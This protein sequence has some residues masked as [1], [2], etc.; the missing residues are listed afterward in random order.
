MDRLM[1]FRKYRIL[2]LATTAVLLTACADSASGTAGEPVR[3]AVNEA[4][5]VPA[6]P[7]PVTQ[8]TDFETWLVRFRGEALAAGISPV[9][10]ERSL[11]G[12]RILPDVLAADS[13]QPEF[14]KPVW[15]YLDGAVSDARVGRGRELL[16]IRQP[17]LA[18]MEHDYGVPAE[19]V[20]AIWGMESNFGANM[21]GHNVIEALAT[22][23]WHGRRAE[24]AREQLLAALRIIDQGDIAPERMV[25]SWA[26]AMGQTQFIPTTF[27][28][29]A[30]DRD[31][32]GR[33]DLWNSLPD[34]FGSTANYLYRSGWRAGE[35]WGAEVLLPANFNY[36]LADL[37]IRKS[38]AEW[39]H[40]GV[41]PMPGTR[42]LRDDAE[43]ALLLPAGFRGPAFLIQDNFRAI[44][45]YNNST[46]YALAVAY[47]GD[48]L[49]GRSPV[50]AAWPR[51]ERPLSRD[52]RVELQTLLAARG[53]SAGTPDGIV[54]VMTRAAIRN[55]QKES[56]LP[57]DGFPT[58]G[59]LSRLRIGGA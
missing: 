24:F 56:G 18:A 58:T 27:A 7:E 52:E 40:L 35:S 11:R 41:Q 22:L 53:Y 2:A 32:D 12:L 49:M 33:R 17:V 30:V 37:S 55:F 34:V 25:G 28:V 46:S 10:V 44:L 3:L 26:G 45:K 51:D 43:A 16:G 8:Q 50:L 36:E 20:V 47:L 39:R 13:S 1:G 14:V 21:G 59:L 9:T 38:V 4:P 48:R 29:H 5:S 57:A 42:T 15:S 6:T 54:G 19:I 23:A 31:G